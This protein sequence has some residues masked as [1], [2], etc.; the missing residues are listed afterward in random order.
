M[1][2]FATITSQPKTAQLTSHSIPKHAHYIINLTYFSLATRTPTLDILGQH[3]T[4]TKF[5]STHSRHLSFEEHDLYLIL[6]P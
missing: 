3:S 5:L 2:T 1:H 4:S 6:K